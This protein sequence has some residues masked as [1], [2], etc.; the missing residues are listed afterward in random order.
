[1]KLKQ[2]TFFRLEPQPFYSNITTIH[3]SL[4]LIDVQS[5]KPIYYHPD[6]ETLATS[7]K[8]RIWKL[9]L[10]N[11]TKLETIGDYAFSSVASSTYSQS[12]NTNGLVFNIS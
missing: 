3:D 7:I 9:D 4:C 11:M 10:S 1:M 5:Y 8:T 12:G 2:N 6:A